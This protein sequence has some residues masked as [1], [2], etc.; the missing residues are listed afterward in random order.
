MSQEKDNFVISLIGNPNVGKSTIFNTLTGMNQRTGNWAGKTVT[1]AKGSFKYK[2]KK[3]SVIDLPGTY[4]INPKS[5]D[6]KV[7]C[8][9]IFN[10][11]SN[12]IVVI[13]SATCLSRS[14]AL[15]LQIMSKTRNIILCVNFMD[16]AKK[17][18]ITINTRK[19]SKILQVPVIE[20]NAR[21]KIGID[22]LK[23]AILNFNVER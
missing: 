20:T 21:N 15:A 12:L 23:E 3:F 2:G 11:K 19:L 13:L 14:L 5:N 16:E 8:D 18:K 17:N 6:E 1:N 7:S 9:Y 10:N 4:S 22:N